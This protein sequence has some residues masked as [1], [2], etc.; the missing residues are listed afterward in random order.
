LKDGNSER[1]WIGIEPSVDRFDELINK[2]DG[3]V[4]DLEP[5]STEF[6]DMSTTSDETAVKIQELFDEGT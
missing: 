3:I 1:E 6:D 4:K 5:V 2:F